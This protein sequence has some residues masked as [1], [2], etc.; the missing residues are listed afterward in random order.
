MFILVTL[1]NIFSTST[2]TTTHA[3][4]TVSLLRAIPLSYTNEHIHTL[5]HRI[6]CAQKEV[7][8]RTRQVDLP[9]KPVMS[10]LVRT[11][12]SP[13]RLHSLGSETISHAHIYRDSA[14][15]NTHLDVYMYKHTHTN[16]GTNIYICEWAAKIIVVHARE[17]LPG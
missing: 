13:V 3:H 15:S 5:E 14:L 10:A 8:E 9:I 6:L 7:H 12:R 17:A 4:K 16:T 1:C 11:L 2:A